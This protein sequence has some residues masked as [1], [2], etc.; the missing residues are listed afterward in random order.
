MKKTIYISEHIVASA[1]EVE[2][3][4]HDRD[5]T[6]VKY[7]NPR[8]QLFHDIKIAPFRAYKGPWG[9]E[10]LY[11]DGREAYVRATEA[12]ALEIR[13]HISDLLFGNH[14]G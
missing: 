5:I 9:R 14:T 1:S 13:H 7:Q 8:H 4:I 11:W 6:E 10:L 2:Q 12:R 3:M